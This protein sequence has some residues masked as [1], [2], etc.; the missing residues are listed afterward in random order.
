[1]TQQRIWENQV[2]EHV[3]RCNM[4]T[5]NLKTAY[6]LIYRQ[7]SDALRAKLESRPDHIAIE[8]AVDS[9]RLLENIRTVMF[10]FQS[11]RY[12]PLALHEA[13]RRFYLF[14]QDQHMTCQQYHET[15]KNNMEVIEYCGGVICNNAGLHSCQRNQGTAPECRGCGVRAGA[16]MCLHSWE[17]PRLVREAIGRS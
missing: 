4:L 10:Q 8:G 15:F 6:S 9:I 11:Q 3:K 14:S 17:R 5:E 12:G 13:K 2:D 16:G 1:M 7:C